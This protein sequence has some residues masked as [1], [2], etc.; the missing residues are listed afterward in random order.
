[1]TGDEH[2]PRRTPR[3][4]FAIVLGIAL[5]EPMA[6]WA[7]LAFPPEGATPTRMHVVDTQGFL[8]AMR[9][10][11]GDFFSPYAGCHAPT[12]T[13]DPSNYALPHH[14][15]YGALGVVGEALGFPMF[16]WLAWI[17]AAG[18]AFYLIAVYLLLRAVVP[19]LANAAFLFFA[20]GGG[21]GGVLYAIAVVTGWDQDPVFPIYFQRYYLYELSEGPRFQP[22][23]IVAKLY[24]TLPLGLGFFG[25]LGM[26]RLVHR[27]QWG[28]A[29]F[30]VLAFALATWINLR[31]GPMI[32]AVGLAYVA[33]RP[34]MPWTRQ[35]ALA[36]YTAAPVALSAFLVLRATA[37]NPE[38]LEAVR[39]NA[40][41]AVWLSPFVSASFW[42][43]WVLP[44][45][46]VRGVQSAPRWLRVAGGAALGYLL[47]Y[48]LLYLA[49]QVYYGNVWRAL[50]VTV[51]IR[52]CDWALLGA[53]PGAYWAHRAHRRFGTSVEYDAQRAWF[54][55]CFLAF[56]AVSISAFGQGWFLR[57]TPD[58]FIVILGVPM[59]A[60]AADRF[61][62]W[63]VRRP[64]AAYAWASA[65]IASG[66]VSIAVT[67]AVSY[68]PLGWNTLQRS[69]PMTR[70]AY[71]HD[72]D[73]ALLDALGPGVVLA[74]SLGAPL[75]GD[76]AVMRPNTATVYGNG[77]IDFSRHVMPRVRSRV[78]AFFQ[79]NTPAAVRRALV[80]EWCV[81]YV[82]CP[83][84]TPV[85]AA[86]RDRLR[87]TPWLETVAAAGDGVLF[88]VS[89]ER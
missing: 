73:A 67:W 66:L 31:T 4:V 27:W 77:T 43:W 85:D 14:R 57:F 48:L 74:P 58:R 46:I 84:T 23:L 49:Y 68:G 37:R 38:L 63:R 6:H 55:L 75:F 16:H 30:T 13:H 19:A 22:W 32:W 71:M 82:Y 36:L 76:I 12:G 29:G 78:H 24:Y 7:I 8:N 44:A 59:A 87:E 81:D 3:W 45:A 40:R 2:N 41:Y 62:D 65:L 70:L 10:A 72:H 33:T 47:A 15:V 17:N 86:T 80:D 11:R 83:D 28:S 26:T 21:L 53:L 64:R 34:L 42:L 5:I 50:D 56:F 61:H 69:F 39:L 25:L 18:M 9:H 1:M 89:G 20:L 88:R 54:A 51:A 79:P 52:M 35:A 60:L